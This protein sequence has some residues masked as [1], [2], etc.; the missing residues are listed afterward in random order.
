MR[1]FRERNPFLVGGISVLALTIAMLFALSLNRLTFLTGVYLA[2]AEFADA[3]GLTPENEVRVAGLKV[4]KVRSVDLD[5]D[6]VLVTFEVKRNIRLGRDS[7]AEIKLK[8]LLGAKF[9]SVT[10]RGGAPFVGDDR[11]IPLERTTIPFEVYQV[12]NESV[13]KLGRL[14]ATALNDALRELARL[15]EDPNGNFGRAFDGLA[16]ATEALSETDAE[17]QS[18]LEATD[19]VTAA[20]AGRS[21]ELAR[22]IDAGADLL[23]ALQARR[24]GLKD[25][26]RGTDRVA[27]QLSRLIRENRSSLDPLLANLHTTLEAVA[28]NV[29]NLEETVRILGPDSESFARAFQQGTWAETFTESLLVPA[30]AVGGGS[31]RRPVFEQVLRAAT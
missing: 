9:L 21:Q 10:P 17:L 22:I 29:A 4:G 27:L 31:T 5:E 18:L 7:T 16:K 13:D 20:L 15:T 8:T 6:R 11:R 3:S 1:P 25:F 30:P 2:E 14:D 26:V 23:G 28:A 19:T 24:Q 12:T